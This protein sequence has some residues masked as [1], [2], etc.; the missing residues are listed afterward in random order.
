[1]R[2]RVQTAEPPPFTSES[3]KPTGTS[4][5]PTRTL[6]RKTRRIRRG[7]RQTP[8]HIL[9]G[10][11]IP[12]RGSLRQNT[13]DETQ[14]SVLES[15]GEPV[16]APSENTVVNDGSKDVFE[17]DVPDQLPFNTDDPKQMET[18]CDVKV[19]RQLNCSPLSYSLHKFVGVS[20]KLIGTHVPIEHRAHIF[21]DD[22]TF[23]L[24]HHRVFWQGAYND[25][26]RDSL[27]KDEHVLKL[28][29]VGDDVSE[30]DQKW[31]MAMYE[32]Y[33]GFRFF[34]QARSEM[35]A[36]GHTILEGVLADH[37]LPMDGIAPWKIDMLNRARPVDDEQAPSVFEMRNMYQTE[38][39]IAGSLRYLQGKF[40][41][42][43]DVPKLVDAEH[44]EPFYRVLNND[45]QKHVC[46]GSGRY[47]TS[48]N[49]VMQM[50]ETE[51]AGEAWKSKAHLDV[52]IAMCVRLM[53]VGCLEGSIL[54]RVTIPKT[55]GR[56]VITASDCARQ[57]VHM[58]GQ[59]MVPEEVVA[60]NGF[61]GLV[62]ICTFEDETP[63]WVCRYSHHTVAQAW[64]IS[65]ACAVQKLSDTVVVEKVMIPPWSIMVA[66]MD[67]RH[68][69]AAATDYDI[70]KETFWSYHMYMVPSGSEGG[71]QMIRAPRF[72][73]SFQE[74]R[75]TA[76]EDEGGDYD[77]ENEDDEQDREEDVV[78]GVAAEEMENV[79]MGVI[80]G[81]VG[82]VVDGA[83]NMDIV[84]M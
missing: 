55:G 28:L 37:L 1:M 47:T 31:A 48:R 19:D 66:R 35:M 75:S 42:S 23:R 38:H 14:Q 46:D 33:R 24:V 39:N 15:A 84:L 68:A 76:E 20:A 5:A 59:T 41:R 49:G 63:V 16:C 44:T 17:D 80:S 70:R 4:V 62:I 21:M 8:P 45:G 50:L 54:E 60:G 74:Y 53:G 11:A 25:L 18:V 22:D 58:A 32:E 83:G 64:L 26:I 77:S 34:A 61:P 7:P 72:N 82:N 73:P 65:K 52:R 36:S 79:V 27:W 30:D 10:H 69:G 43:E 2:P 6:S 81:A 3:T 12:H 67:L 40:P 78:M 51:E 13:V 56:F 71:D 9:P 29:K 57:V